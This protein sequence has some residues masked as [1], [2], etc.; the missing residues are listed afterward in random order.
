MLCSGY[1]GQNNRPLDLPELVDGTRTEG[2]LRDGDESLP[3]A[4]EIAQPLNQRAA[5]P[6]EA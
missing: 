4:A 3:S 5:E 1:V 2:R 6:E